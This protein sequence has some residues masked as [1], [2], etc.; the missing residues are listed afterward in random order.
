MAPTSAVRPVIGK[1]GTASDMKFDAGGTLHFVWYDSA[2]KKM[3]YA[4]R[5]VDG[6]WSSI[7]I[8]D[9]SGIDAGSNLSLAVASNG[10]P[11]VAYYDATNG[12][13]R[14]AAYSGSLYQVRRSSD[15]TTTN[16]GVLSAGGVANA[17]AQDSFCAGT[18]CVITASA[19]WT[20]AT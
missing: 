5:D 13:L 15:N 6:A 20:S 4:M 3:K 1:N 10:K 17:A 16:I 11:S 19:A 9:N 2:A 8:I 7:Q 18:S 14:Y 12:D